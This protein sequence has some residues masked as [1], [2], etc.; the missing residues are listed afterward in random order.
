MYISLVTETI[1]NE[2]GHAEYLYGKIDFENLFYLTKM[3]RHF[4][5]DKYF[6][7][8]IVV[9]NDEDKNG[10]NGFFFK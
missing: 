4:I 8:V 5:L 10:I 1:S 2:I 3:S 6:V 9:C 7:V